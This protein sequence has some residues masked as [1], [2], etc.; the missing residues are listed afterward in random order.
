[1]NGTREDGFD[2]CKQK[3][4]IQTQLGHLQLNHYNL[5]LQILFLYLEKITKIN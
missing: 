2:V 5:T 1:M 3:D 4:G